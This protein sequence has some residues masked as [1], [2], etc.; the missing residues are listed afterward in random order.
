M[1]EL[2]AGLERYILDHSDPEEEILQELCRETHLKVLRPRMLSGHLQGHFLKLICRM[3]AAK[4]VLEIGTYTGYAAISMALGMDEGVVHTIDKD[5]ELEEFARR[6]IDKSG[7]SHRIVMH[8]GDACDIIPGLDGM[9][10]LVFIDA[11]KREYENY[12]RLVFDKVRPGGVIIADDVLWDGKVLE[13]NDKTDPQT[14]GILRFNEMIR[15]DK[16]VEKIMLPFRHGITMIVKKN[17]AIR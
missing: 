2:D 14:A 1:L 3:I 15:E 17:Q 10:D 13:T 9:F 11:D 7:L 5:D 6:F 8:L 4:R 12:Y 16:R